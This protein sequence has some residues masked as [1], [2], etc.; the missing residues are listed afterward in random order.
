MSNLSKISNESCNFY[1]FNHLKNSKHHIMRPIQ[2]YLCLERSSKTK[3]LYFNKLL[4]LLN[5]NT[6][7]QVLAVNNN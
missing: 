7:L 4:V 3:E 5:K 2:Q 1:S 6:F